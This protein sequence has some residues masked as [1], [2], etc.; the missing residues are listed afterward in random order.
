MINANVSS[1]SDAETARTRPECGLQRA[2][3]LAALGVKSV[4]EL[5]VGPSLGTLAAAYASF[6]IRTVGNDIDPRWRMFDPRSEWIVGDALDVNWSGFDAV[7]FAP[8]LSAGCTGRREDALCVDQVTPSYESFVHR[9]NQ[10]RG[11]VGVM[12]LP[13]RATAT[14]DDRT[15]LW[16]LLSLVPDG[17]VVPLTAGPRKIVKYH[18]VYMLHRV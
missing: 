13:A 11:I 10:E 6:G 16:K 9:F 7:V 15:R 5:C 12:V 8:P 3:N 17:I 2:R 18:D 14:R 1:V 4:L